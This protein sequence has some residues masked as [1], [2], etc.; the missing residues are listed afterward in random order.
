MTDQGSQLFSA[1]LHQM[2]QLIHGF[3]TR[4]GDCCRR[5]TGNS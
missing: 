3:W 2:T 4:S 5:E 1:E